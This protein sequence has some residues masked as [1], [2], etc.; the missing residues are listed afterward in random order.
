MS[1]LRPEDRR[2]TSKSLC[3]KGR[4]LYGEALSIGAGIK[5]Q[6]C[7]TC[8]EV[9]IDLTSLEEVTEPVLRNKS[10]ITALSHDDS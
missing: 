3:R 1:H 9:T 7:E 5:R 10:S 8:G 6:V 2:K 4:H